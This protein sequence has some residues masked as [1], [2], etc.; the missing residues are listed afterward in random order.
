MDPFVVSSRRDWTLTN[1][2]VVGCEAHPCASSCGFTPRR[3]SRKFVPDEFFE[4]NRAYQYLWERLCLKAWPFLLGV[5]VMTPHQRPVVGYQAHPCAWPFGLP[6]SGV[7]QNCSGQFCRVQ[8]CLT[9]FEVPAER[10]LHLLALIVGP[11]FP[12]EGVGVRGLAIWV[13]AT[14]PLKD[15]FS[16]PK[17]VVVLSSVWTS[18]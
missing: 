5:A 10:R 8:S 13:F 16:L 18:V 3:G 11:I 17:Q 2:C 12:G 14:I 7:V 9:Q 6:R 1:D 15:R 4:S